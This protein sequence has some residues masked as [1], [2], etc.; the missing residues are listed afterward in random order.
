MWRKG[1]AGDKYYASMG[2]IKLVFLRYIDPNNHE[3]LVD[4]VKEKYWSPVDLYIGGAEHATRHLIYARFWYKFLYDIKVVS[5]SE[6]FKKYSNLGLIMGEDGR[7]MSKRWGM[8]L[9]LMK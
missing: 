5:Y 6:P 8:W 4:Q 2:R 7:K 9:I 3:K 1:K